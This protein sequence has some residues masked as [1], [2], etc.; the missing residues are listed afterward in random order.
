MH[1][2]ILSSDLE[3]FSHEHPAMVPGGMFR[4]HTTLPK[5]GIYKMFAD[6]YPL[7]GT[8]QLVPKIISTQ[9]FRKS[10]DETFAHPSRDIA[11]SSRES[12]SR[13]LARSD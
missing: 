11:P 13:S 2:F 8:P 4:H 3:Y 9:G 10:I 5:P 12:Q 6:F 1:F 7:N